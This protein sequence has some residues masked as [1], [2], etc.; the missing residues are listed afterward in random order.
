MKGNLQEYSTLS[1]VL[2]IYIHF[3]DLKVISNCLFSV[4]I[5]LNFKFGFFRIVVKHIH[6]VK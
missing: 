2:Q 1:S 5:E 4:T 3:A 6:G